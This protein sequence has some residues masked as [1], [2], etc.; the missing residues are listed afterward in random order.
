[1]EIG[2]FDNRA[3]AEK[4]SRL[5]LRNPDTKELLIDENGKQVFVMVRGTA[6]RT[7][8]EAMRARQ[9]AR[10]IE[11]K[12]RKATGDDELAYVAEDG[13]NS[14]VEAALPYIMGFENLEMNGKPLTLE[15][16]KDFLDMTFPDMGV[17]VDDNGNAV[18]VEGRDKDG[19]VVMVPKFE[20][21]NLPFAKQVT[22]HAAETANFLDNAAKS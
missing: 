21:R 17:A 2:K 3:R 13:H 9:K 11:N 5:A 1:M 14:M 19:K 7:L 15:H 6:S 20:L 16:A 10:L 4:G 12:K 8:Q 22:D 18:L